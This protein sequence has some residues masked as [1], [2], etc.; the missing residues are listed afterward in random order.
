MTKYIW[1]LVPI[2][3]IALGCTTESRGERNSPS[4]ETAWFSYPDSTYCSRVK[5]CEVNYYVN[6]DTL[7]TSEKYHFLTL[8]YSW[9]E[10]NSMAY[11]HI[12][13]FDKSQEADPKG[14]YHIVIDQYNIPRESATHLSGLVLRSYMGEKYDYKKPGQP[15]A[16][17]YLYNATTEIDADRE[18]SKLSKEL[19]KL[20]EIIK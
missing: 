2:M 7:F 12:I 18:R 10:D 20:Y 15:H 13:Y 16:N 1:L 5:L 8:V 6:G 9:D 3:L 17:A 19:S 11:Q 14:W 4:Y